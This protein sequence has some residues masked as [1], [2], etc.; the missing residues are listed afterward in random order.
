MPPSAPGVES[1]GMDYAAHYARLIER[2]RGRKLDGYKERHHVIPRCMGG[3]NSSDNIVELTGEE[4]YVAHQLLVKLHPEHRGLS[5]AAVWMA[6]QCTLGNK[7]YGWLRRRHA[8]AARLLKI[9]TKNSPEACAKISAKRR[10]RTITPDTAKKISIANSGRKF[11]KEHRA[12]IASA[13]RGKVRSKEH[14]ENL[15][16]AKMGKH[17]YTPSQETRDKIRAAHLGKPLTEER[18]ANISASLM[19]RTLTP[20][21]RAKV[22]VTLRRSRGGGN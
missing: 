17:S 7:A 2:A 4:H 18:K 14:R 15:S 20:E 8:S 5:H 9:G 1:G 19:G 12:K 22:V 16:A 21:H 13:L 11:T 6:K 10:L 3:G